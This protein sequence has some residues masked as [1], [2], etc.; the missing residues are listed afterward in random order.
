MTWR[1]YAMRA[2]TGE[3]LHR[4]LPLSDVRVSPALSG[5]YKLTATVDPEY[6]DLY[7]DDG[8]LL[9][10]E[11]GTIIVA[12]ASNQLRGGGIVTD[13]AIVGSKLTLTVDGFTRYPAGQPLTEALTWGGKTA[14]TTGYGVDPLD[15]VRALWGH[16][17]AQPDGNLGVT[18]TATTSP[19]RVGEWHNTRALDADGS[20]GDDPKAVAT[21]PVPID[22]VWDPKKDKKPVAAQGKTVYWQY[23][24]PWW[25]G[26]EIGRH[27]E[28]L[29]RQVPFDW[30]ESYRWADA[31]KE[32]VVME[33]QLGYPRLGRRQSGLAFREGENIVELVPVSRSGDDYFNAVYGYGAGEG[34][35]KLRQVASQRDGVRLRRAT[36]ADH[37][38]ITNAA[39]LRAEA[40]DE[41]RRSV[42]L[43][44]ITSF[45]IRDHPNARIGSFDVGDDVLVE[46]RRGWQPTR[47]WVRIT[48]FD[49]SPTSGEV[50]VRCSRS[51]RFVYGGS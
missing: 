24:L 15:V 10:A 7:A 3:W 16:L 22:K 49:Y 5:P 12:E 26:I 27:I 2:T 20:L 19:Y 21:S 23:Q 6:A 51:D 30:R 48:G 34:S 36:V 4:Q 39:A 1:Y 25:D 43:V 42:H 35:K 37:P 18:I 40:G 47:L 41:L 46:T 9:L 50:T 44:D 32:A 29:A 11:W 14:G 8:E 17:Q 31:S 45:T 28:E 38:E 13:T 33:L